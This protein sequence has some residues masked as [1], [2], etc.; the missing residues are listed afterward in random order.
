[1]AS[2]QIEI[3]SAVKT[4]FFSLPTE[5]RQQ[6]LLEA[7]ESTK[8]KDVRRYALVML[9]ELERLH[10][11]TGPDHEMIVQAEAKKMDA[12]IEDMEANNESMVLAFGYSQL[13]AYACGQL[14]SANGQFCSS[15]MEHLPRIKALFESVREAVGTKIN[16]D[17]QY[18]LDV[19]MAVFKP[20]LG[21]V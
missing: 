6:I 10:D 14:R 19:C 21:R 20:K 12:E 5:L 3:A 2:T 4:T 11:P 13:N 16:G 17:L 8:R 1:M 9:Y 15:M 18:V 7:F